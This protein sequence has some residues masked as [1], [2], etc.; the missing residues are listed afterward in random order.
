MP[1]A[2]AMKM[3]VCHPGRRNS[4]AIVTGTKTSSRFS[5]RGYR[6]LILWTNSVL[7]AARRI[8]EAAG[9]RL[10]REELHHGFGRDLVGQYWELPLAPH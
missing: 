3:A 6:S 7:V 5:T 10:V 9:F 8:Y 1:K 2:A 4:S